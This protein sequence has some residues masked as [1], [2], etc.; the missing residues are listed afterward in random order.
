MRRS[1]ASQLKLADEKVLNL[2]TLSLS[3]TWLGREPFKLQNV[4]SIP[5]RD[6]IYLIYSRVA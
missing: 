4:G 3:S 2:R 1:S 5:R 6:A